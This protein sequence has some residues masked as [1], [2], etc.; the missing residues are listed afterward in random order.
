MRGREAGGGLA[1]QREAMVAERLFGVSA[2][3]AGMFA[4]GGVG[5]GGGTGGQSLARTLQG[6]FVAGLRGAQVPEFLQTLVGLQQEA[7]K[8][9]IKIDPQDFVKM[10]LTLKAGG[11]QGAQIGRVGGQ[12]AQ[13]TMGL[14]QRGVQSPMDML[15]LRSFGFDPSK[16]DSYFSALVDM[17]DPEKRSGGMSTF[18]EQIAKG[19]T[20]GTKD[21][22]AVMGSRALKAAGIQLG[23]SDSAIL[24][25]KIRAG[26][27]IDADLDRQADA[28]GAKG[29]AAAATG[30]MTKTGV[31]GITK[32][33]A[34]LQAGAIDLGRQV[35]TAIEG[36]EKNAQRAGRLM[37]QF[38]GGLSKIN[39]AVEIFITSLDKLLK[40]DFAGALKQILAALAGVKPPGIPP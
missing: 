21:R 24:L 10:S 16:P 30:L 15:L 40:G 4:R 1:Q 13:S 28:G 36:M 3:Q 26:I 29:A 2:Q 14:S 35:A 11:L 37:G 9:G 32:G 31:G 33:R 38:A 8:Q 19:T 12:F 39:D 6:A 25:D 20:A 17:Q 22:Q 18:F 34:R 23:F 5:G 7:E 27:N